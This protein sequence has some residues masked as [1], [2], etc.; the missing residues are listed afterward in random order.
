MSECP[1]DAVIPIPESAGD[2]I[3]NEKDR[4]RT[5]VRGKDRRS[6]F[7]EVSVPVIHRED[8]RVFP[9]RSSL[10]EMCQHLRQAHH[11]VTMLAQVFEVAGK[12]RQ[13]MPANAEIRHCESVQEEH[14]GAARSQGS[15]QSK[16]DVTRDPGLN[17][18]L[19][20]LKI[21]RERVLSC[22]RERQGKLD[23][24]TMIFAPRS[25]G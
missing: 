14:G 7:G 23:C 21:L 9:K 19:D 25:A 12:G 4:D 15:E 11:V 8:Q 18:F 3:R 2:E 17:D 6:G 1:G 16:S 10:I 22:L 13:I 20:D 24:D 5:V